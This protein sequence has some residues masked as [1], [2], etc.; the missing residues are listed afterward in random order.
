MLEVEHDLLF[1]KSEI[2]EEPTEIRLEGFVDKEENEEKDEKDDIKC[3]S[4]DDDNKFS[5]TVA[6][7]CIVIVTIHGRVVRK[8]R[9]DIIGFYIG[10]VSGVALVMNVC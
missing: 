4:N 3:K 2:L 8:R 6:A 7:E 1:G 10:I 5:D 9:N